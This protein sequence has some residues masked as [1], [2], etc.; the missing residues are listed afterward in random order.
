MDYFEYPR[1]LE[2]CFSPPLCLDQN[3]TFL[4][5]GLTCKAFGPAPEGLTSG[6]SCLAE[7]ALVTT[8]RKIMETFIYLFTSR[9][10]EAQRVCSIKIEELNINSICFEEK[11]RYFTNKRSG[12]T[13]N[14]RNPLSRRITVKSNCYY[15]VRNNRRGVH[16]QDLL[17]TRV[18]QLLFILDVSKRARSW[19]QEIW[20]S[21]SWEQWRNGSMD[22]STEHTQNRKCRLLGRESILVA[23]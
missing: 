19:K 9:T 1:G 6:S 23:P 5:N 16:L 17:Q 12:L 11:R 22:P 15:S 4:P 18:G 3:V 20:G 8:E 7:S 2:R 10:E 21:D 14:T 13:H